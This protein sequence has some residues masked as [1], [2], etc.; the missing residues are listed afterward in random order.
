MS[1]STTKYYSVGGAMATREV[2]RPGN[3]HRTS[4]SARPIRYLLTSLYGAERRFTCV[5]QLIRQP[6]S[7]TGGGVTALHRSAAGICG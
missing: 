3:A 5:T 6:R 2:A 1:N 4:I 7:L